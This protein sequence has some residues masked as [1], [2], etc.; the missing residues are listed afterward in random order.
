MVVL[1]EGS[2]VPLVL[3][4]Y[5]HCPTYQYSGPAIL[6]LGTGNVE[7]VEGVNRALSVT[8]EDKRFLKEFDVQ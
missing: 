6:V 1:L 2:I 7:R 4:P 8:L 3:R 5:A